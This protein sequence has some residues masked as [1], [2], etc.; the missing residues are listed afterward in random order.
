MINSLSYFCVIPSRS[1]ENRVIPQVFDL[2]AVKTSLCGNAELPPW[3]GFTLRVMVTL[4]AIQELE[5][6]SAIRNAHQCLC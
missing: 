6:L 4:S 5:S 2:S 1:S 3:K